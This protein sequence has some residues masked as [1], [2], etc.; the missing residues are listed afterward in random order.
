MC[1][2][3]IA[4]FRLF[5]GLARNLICQ[6]MLKIFLLSEVKQCQSRIVLF[7]FGD[8]DQLVETLSFGE[9]IFLEINF[10]KFVKIF[11][12]FERSF[13]LDLFPDRK[14]NVL[15]QCFESFRFSFGQLVEKLFELRQQRTLFFVQSAAQ[16]RMNFVQNDFFME[17]QQKF[18]A[19]FIHFRKKEN[20][21][22]RNR[23]FIRIEFSCTMNCTK[24]R[25]KLTKNEFFTFLQRKIDRWKEPRPSRSFVELKDENS[26]S[27]VQ[28][29]VR[30]LTNIQVFRHSSAQS[31]I[32]VRIRPVEKNL[33]SLVIS[34]GS[35]V[36]KG[37]VESRKNRFLWNFFRLT[38]S[39]RNETK[40]FC[41][42]EKIDSNKDF[43]SPKESVIFHRDFPQNFSR[44][45]VY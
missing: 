15:E 45:I 11:D 17:F 41:L 20:F 7:S 32:E 9:S 33:P 29:S 18:V 12:L 37:R 4:R 36:T 27:S 24:K 31:S 2:P 35:R 6:K 39:F 34:V 28:S 10:E 43:F 16:R 26:F 44:S 19:I 42:P 5:I 23:L 22:I 1:L 21:S 3:V 13:F 40:V 25:L 38:K 14:T 8:F 30:K